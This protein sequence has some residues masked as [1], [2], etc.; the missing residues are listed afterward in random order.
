MNPVLD[1]PTDIRLMAL[2]TQLL[3]GLFVLMGLSAAGLWVVRHPAWTLAGIE[4]R[5]DVARQNEVSLRAH[6]AT[7]LS[8]SF[9]SLDLNEARRLFESVPWVRQAV[10][11]RQFPNRLR[12]TLTE[13]Q[14]VAWWGQAG[15]ERLL[16]V[17]GEV[18]EANA[19]HLD[20]DALIELAGPDDQAPQVLGLY[21]DLSSVFG[22]IDLQIRRLE[23]SP[24]GNWQV[25]LSNQ[26][27]IE[28]GRGEPSE[29]LARAGQFVATVGQV[30]ERYQRDIESA[31]LR[32][33]NGYAVRMRGVSTL[34]AGK[35][36]PRTP[37]PR[38]A[39]AAAAKPQNNKP[40]PTHR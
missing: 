4:V 34:E 35:L 31:D 2:A 24:R 28:L 14:A 25:L 39:G 16:D 26:A 11:Q 23:L 37:A 1:T 10:V 7:R 15:G 30:T 13:H 32:Y 40:T 17:D 29:L 19:D 6:I 3:V 5:G 36:P 33:P 18:F 38:A 8:G 20:D 12:V 27:R 9:L 21:R 22:R